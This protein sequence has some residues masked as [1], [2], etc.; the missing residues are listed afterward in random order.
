M[1]GSW[2]WHITR[3]PWPEMVDFARLPCRNHW[4]HTTARLGSA[5]MGSACCCHHS[6]IVARFLFYVVFISSSANHWLKYGWN[7]AQYVEI[8]SP[9]LSLNFQFGQRHVIQHG[10][11]LE[12][13]APWSPSG[14]LRSATRHLP[15]VAAATPQVGHGPLGRDRSGPEGRSR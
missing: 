1:P 8:Q 11:S 15:T 13:A 4:R 9:L 10:Q 6:P 7:T 14:H 3:S 2:F 12:A 5:D